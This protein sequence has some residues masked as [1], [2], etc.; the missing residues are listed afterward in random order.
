MSPSKGFRTLLEACALVAQRGVD[1]RL[2]LR[3]P[4][5]TDEERRHEQE[6]RELVETRALDGHV[7]VDGPVPYSAV[8]SLLGRADAVVNPT[9][10]QTSGG[11]L[12]KIVYETAACA[13]PVLACNPHFDEFLAD[14]PVELRFR[15]DDAEDLARVLVAFAGSPPEARRET[16][17]EL[18]RR[19]AA[20][21]SVET[22]ADR[23]VEAIRA[24]RG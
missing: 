18:Q 16:G 21:H 14:L 8:P 3:G 20:D 6:L 11:A 5:T 22:W 24:A 13:V 10:G 9:R 23:V 7:R 19:V 15:S 1:F 17:R 4:A 2:D 12:D